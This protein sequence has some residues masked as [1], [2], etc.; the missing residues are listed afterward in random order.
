M[1]HAGT[2]HMFTATGKIVGK[3]RDTAGLSWEGPNLPVKDQLFE[4]AIWME[5]WA[6]SQNG[7]EINVTE[8]YVRAKITKDSSMRVIDAPMK[9]VPSW[10]VDVVLPTPSNEVQ[11]ALKRSDFV[12]FEELGLGYSY[13]EMEDFVWGDTTPPDDNGIPQVRP[14]W[15]LAM[16][17]NSKWFWTCGKT[18]GRPHAVSGMNGMYPRKLP[19]AMLQFD[20]TQ[21]SDKM[22][23]AL[24]LLEPI[25]SNMYRMMGIDLT[26]K[27]EWKCSLHS[28]RDMYLG[29]ASG[30]MPTISE[31]IKIAN[32]EY[33]KISNRGKKIEFH[34]QV[35]MQIY[36]FIIFGREPNVV[37]VLPPKN[38]VFFDFTKQLNDAE[39]MGFLNKIRLFNI[40]SA[41]LIYLERIAGL[42]RHLLE[43]GK[44][45]RIGQKWGHGGSD[46]LAECLGVTPEN[47]WDETIIEGDFK[48]FDQSIRMV[49]LKIYRSQ[50]T[51]HYDETSP[52][53][54]ILERIVNFILEVTCYRIT[55]LMS[56]LWV[57]LEGSVAS[58]EFDTSHM[59]SWITSF[60]FSGFMMWMLFKTPAEHQEELELYMIAIIKL[61][62]YGDDHLYQVG[63]AKWSSMFGGDQWAYYCKTF[64]NM[65]VRDLKKTSY[66]TAH[67]HGWIT[68]MGVTFLKYQQVLNEEKSEGQ[69]HFLPYRETRDFVVRAVYSREP[70]IRDAIDVMLSVIGQAYST[71]ASNSNAYSRLRNFYQQLYECV[72]DKSTLKEIMAKRLH[73]AQDIRRIRQMGITPDELVEGFPTWEK[74][75][76]KNVVDKAYLDNS[77]NDISSGTD[78]DDYEGYY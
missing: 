65:D 35:L 54:P 47:C 30:L 58:G 53:F 14:L 32:D 56:Q 15:A 77:R 71:Y 72:T 42:E 2:M 26:K 46:A 31:M 25:L 59:D 44:Q 20:R 33:I 7:V 12:D 67:K 76:E 43:R 52:D 78:Y 18:N 49:L 24:Y 6:R 70:K 51:I 66:C 29:A 57:I 37:W 69:P 60:V 55:Y 64:W 28:C 19:D 4:A 34:E 48:K 74:L 68:K 21:N 1:H 39:W 38:E 50:T 13:S 8:Q 75:V 41:V 3:G 5:A 11:E 40:P 9:V 62:C 16:R 73:E 22:K 10:P 63:Q 27:R 36:E 17:A 45:I 61:V 23:E